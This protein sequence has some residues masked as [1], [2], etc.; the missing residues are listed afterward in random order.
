MSCDYCDEYKGIK[1]VYNEI[2]GSLD[3]EVYSTKKFRV[4]PCMGQLREG[5]LLIVIKRHTNCIGMLSKEELR[6]LE[7]IVLK[8]KDFYMNKYGLYT[9]CFEHGV[10]CDD[11]SQ[12]GCGIYHMHLHL[13]PIKI[14]EYN[15]IL[16]CLQKDKQNII[17]PI[18]GFEDIDKFVKQGKTYIFISGHND[19]LNINGYILLNENNFFESQYMR[20]IIAYVLKHE[21]WDWR[22]VNCIEQEL[23]NT[24][25]YAKKFFESS[26]FGLEKN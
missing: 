15:E 26:K 5:H 21:K 3:R 23:L 24:I 6:E 14:G 13:L 25:K 1:T 9:L 4:F 2:Y 19:I 11:G 22:S 10:L 17:Y 8:I 20:K 7:E 16:N 12:G 18:L